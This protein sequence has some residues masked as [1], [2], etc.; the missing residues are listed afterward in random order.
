MRILLIRHG[1]TEGNRQRRYIGVTDEPLCPEGI[2][3]LEQ[4]RVPFLPD[5][6]Y[7]S[8]MLRC[9]QTAQILFP[10]Q[11]LTAIREL[12]EMDF[13]IFENRCWADDLE[14]DPRYLQ[15]LDGRCEGQVPDGEGK[16][17]FTRRCVEGFHKALALADGSPAALVV[18]GGTI[19]SILSEYAEDGGE[20]YS[21]NPA[22][23]HGYAA[24]WD[25]RMLKAVQEF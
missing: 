25:G 1:M 2:R 4:T 10:E 7:V 14:H 16:A 24:E 3:Q 8:P 22:N 6:I 20:Y 12:R 23:G 13:G 19:M 9:V 17:G 11:E 18:H 21:W 5:R 15:W